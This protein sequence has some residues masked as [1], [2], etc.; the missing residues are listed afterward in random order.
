MDRRRMIA[1]RIS[2]AS[3]P[4]G[5]RICVTRTLCLHFSR[6]CVHLQCFRREPLAMPVTMPSQSRPRNHIVTHHAAY[7]SIAANFRT[8]E[9]AGPASNCALLLCPHIKPMCHRTVSWYRM[10]HSCGPSDL[11]PVAGFPIAATA[12]SYLWA[13]HWKP[14]P[15]PRPWLEPMT[16]CKSRPKQKPKLKPKRT[17][18]V[19]GEWPLSTL[20]SF[21]G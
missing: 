9:N 2:T 13:L 15:K 5:R 10:Q 8:T 7:H 16:I 11:I 20:A 6:E 18:I 4:E 17:A 21:D 12:I 14:K 19:G 3:G 1:A